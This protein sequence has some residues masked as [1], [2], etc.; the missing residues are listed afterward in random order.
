SEA[1]PYHRQSILAGRRMAA[2]RK[3]GNRYHCCNTARSARLPHRYLQNTGTG[4]RIAFC[5][6][7]LI[8]IAGAAWADGVGDLHFKDVSGHPANLDQA[9]LI[10]FWS[11]DCAPCLQEMKILPDI[12]KQNGDVPMALISLKGAEHTRAHLSPMPDNV[13]VLVAQKEGRAV[14]T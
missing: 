2:G 10:T 14:L 5:I 9:W 13:Q 6:V 3:C 1:Y 8:A 12:A 7:G 11:S 4:M